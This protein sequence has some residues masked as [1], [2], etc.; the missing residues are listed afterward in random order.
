MQGKQA[1]R[2]GW[3]HPKQMSKTHS[4]DTLDYFAARPIASPERLLNDF[5][6]ALGEVFAPSEAAALAVLCAHVRENM[7]ELHEYRVQ[8][9]Q[10]RADEDELPPL[11]DHAVVDFLSALERAAV[12]TLQNNDGEV[13]KWIGAAAKQMNPLLS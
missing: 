4:Q 13:V 11:L 6:S 5:L 10:E 9:F 3:M 12:E 8:G 2:A 1:E 7:E